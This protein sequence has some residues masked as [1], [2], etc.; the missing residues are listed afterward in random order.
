MKDKLINLTDYCVLTFAA[1]S[2]ALKAEK[3]LK[4][5]QTE[6]IMMPTLREISTSCGLSI[7]L[8]EISLE[9][10]LQILENNKV[11]VEAVYRIQKKDKTNV[12]QDLHHVSKR[13]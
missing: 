12:V 11:P 6:F 4:K 1:T 10:Y 9:N 2:H 8:E 3:V 5:E 7:K 13:S